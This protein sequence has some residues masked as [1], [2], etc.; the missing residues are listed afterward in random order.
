MTMLIV[1]I[2]FR[3][4]DRLLPMY[5][6][7]LA[8]T[9]A[10]NIGLTVG[11]LFGVLYQGNLFLSTVLSIFIGM[12][13]GVFCGI[14]FGVVSSIEGAMAGLMGSMM[15]AMLGEMISVPQAS[16]MLMILLT[17]SS[18][19]ILLFFILGPNENQGRKSNMISLLLTPTLV[20]IALGSYLLFGFELSKDN[21]R[22]ENHS[23]Q[24]HERHHGIHLQR[25]H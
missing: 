13:I 6:M 14:C 10:M 19:S 22:T 2:S 23:E 17:F 7:V 1:I 12:T 3:L 15:G 4:K 18:C 24:N 16:T 8:M 25:N 21:A 9:F 20:M 5:K 11:V